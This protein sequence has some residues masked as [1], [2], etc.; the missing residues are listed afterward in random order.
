MVDTRFKIGETYTREAIQ[1][2]CSHSKKTLDLT[3]VNQTGMIFAYLPHE[4][5][6]NN[7]VWQTHRMI[8]ERLPDNQFKILS[9]EGVFNY[10]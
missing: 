2:G 7:Q 10:R 4:R 9:Y 3:E 6:I 5:F 8:V 1:K